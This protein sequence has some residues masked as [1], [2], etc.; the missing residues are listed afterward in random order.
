MR[1]LLG[2][3]VL[4]V[5]AHARAQVYNVLE[6]SSVGPHFAAQF[7]FDVSGV[8]GPIAD[9]DVRLAMSCEDVTGISYDLIAP[10]GLTGV[11]WNAPL[12]TGA[13]FQDTYLDDE[14]DGSRIGKAGS[15]I[16][17]FAAPEWGG[18]RYRPSTD[19]N[20]FDGANPNGIWLL[21]VYTS[22]LSPRTPGYIRMANPP[23]GAKQLAPNCSSHPFQSL[24]A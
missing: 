15:N 16:A 21:I 13:H 7:F 20:G 4:A 1:I 17:P 22:V 19:L 6:G 3:T 14:A 10:S 9:V 8:G 18:R 11:N 12:G 2:L 5:G 23:H 24:P